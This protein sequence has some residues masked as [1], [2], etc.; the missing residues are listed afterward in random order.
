MSDSRALA[1]SIAL[2][3]SSSTVVIIFFIRIRMCV[4]TSLISALIC[5]KCSLNSV[6]RCT[7][8]VR[9]LFEACM[10]ILRQAVAATVSMFVKLPDAAIF[11]IVLAI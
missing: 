5:S 3:R 6:A 8:R 10:V 1:S 7:Y 9:V 2:D 11:F 4:D